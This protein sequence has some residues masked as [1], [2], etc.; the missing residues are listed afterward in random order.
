MTFIFGSPFLRTPFPLHTS[1]F[2]RN[3]KMG[4]IKI[5]V[6]HLAEIESE[7]CAYHKIEIQQMHFPKLMF[8]CTSKI[9]P[10]QMLHEVPWNTIQNFE[11]IT[12]CIKYL[13]HSL[14]LFVEQNLRRSV[15]RNRAGFKKS[16]KRNKRSAKF[17]RLS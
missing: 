4:V 12:P 5:A 15:L 16:Q 9:S 7:R 1:H 17:E 3:R 6:V 13:F 2:P 10:F 14:K 8:Y 11:H